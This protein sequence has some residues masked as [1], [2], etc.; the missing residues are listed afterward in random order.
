MVTY[1]Y[2]SKFIL[3]GILILQYTYVSLESF[4]VVKLI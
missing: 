2:D 1:K 3:E 4:S